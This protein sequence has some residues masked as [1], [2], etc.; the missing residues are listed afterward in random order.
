ME[1]GSRVVCLLGGSG[2]IGRAI[3]TQLG[4]AGASVR[5]LSRTP[6][7]PGQW[8]YRRGDPA[9]LRAAFEG[10]DAVVHLIGILAETSRE[11]FFTVQRDGPAEAARVARECGVRDF[12]LVSAL[13]AD[14]ASPSRYARSKAEGEDAVRAAFPG[15][16]IVRPSLVIG[17]GDGFFGRFGAMAAVSPVLPLIGGGHSKFQPV[18][19]GDVARAVLACL[20]DP[21]TR[22][23]IFEL[24][25]PQVFSFRE[26]LTRMLAAQRRHRVLVTLPWWLARL[27]AAVMERLPDPMLT[28]DQLK[29]LARD[30][31]VGA[32]AKSLADL[33]IAGLPL[34]ATLRLMYPRSPAA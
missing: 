30:N 25:G 9:S 23:A 12:V 13:G 7:G 32:E 4:E 1:L 22:G 27:Q 15:A 3:A 18:Y 2:F 8:L 29:L 19:V 16:V 24:G 28:R 26:L 10:A 6:R 21:A 11:D 20:A 14:A 17:P 31:V 33:G 34:D 5:T